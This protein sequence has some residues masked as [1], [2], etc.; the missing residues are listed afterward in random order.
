MTRMK[1][2]HQFSEGRVVLSS[3]FSNFA[4]GGSIW[5]KSY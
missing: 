4:R 1:E 2:K 3:F 5:A